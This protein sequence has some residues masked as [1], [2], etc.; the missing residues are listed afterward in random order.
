MLQ[1]KPLRIPSV[2]IGCIPVHEGR[3]LLVRSHRGFW[4]T[5]GGH[6]DYG[7]SPAEAAVRETREETGVTVRDIEFVAITNDVIAAS[8]KHY[9]TLWFRGA[10]EDP[11]L[12]IHDTSEIAEALWCDPR[13]LPS[14]RHVYFEN[15][16][17]GRCW[18][19]VPSNLPPLR[20]SE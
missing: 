10:V 8:A 12:T 4:S 11:A 3:V 20:A 1:D 19:P 9:I 14:P 17:S 7:E 16:I 5:P 15:L 18:P 13:S 2:G 6:L